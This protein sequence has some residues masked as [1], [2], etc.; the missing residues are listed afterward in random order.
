MYEVTDVRT[1][2]RNVRVFAQ[3]YFSDTQSVDVVDG[4]TSSAD[5]AP[6]PR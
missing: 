4:Q 3:G 5:F 1:G 6:E 2:T